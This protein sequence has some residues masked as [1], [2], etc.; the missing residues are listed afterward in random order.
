MAATTWEKDYLKNMAAPEN[1]TRDEKKKRD[2]SRDSSADE[3]E[4]KSRQSK[5]KP[6]DR[7]SKKRL[8]PSMSHLSTRYVSSFN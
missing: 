5:E 8:V 2:T 1:G 7:G 4:K 6:R 3:K